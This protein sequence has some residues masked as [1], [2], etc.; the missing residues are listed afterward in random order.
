MFTHPVLTEIADAHGESVPQVVLRWLIQRD[1]V[2]IPKS[3]RPDR[4]A[5]NLDVFA[6]DLTDDQ[7]ARIAALDTGRSLFFD[8][9]DP[10][11]TARLGTVRMPD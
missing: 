1:V 5:Q 11:V 2:I 6:F 10:V 8:H 9:R 3:V 7:M 4:M